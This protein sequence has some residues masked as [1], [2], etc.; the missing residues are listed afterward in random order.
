[1]KVTV[2][3]CDCCGKKEEGSESSDLCP[4]VLVSL[5]DKA[6]HVRTSFRKW[7]FPNG[8]REI[9]LCQKCKAKAIHFA[10]NFWFS[11]KGN[12]PIFHDAAGVTETV[13]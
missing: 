10:G 11:C 3:V 7:E 6:I 13:Q 4:S 12:V 9:D 1:M 2:I 5:K 8:S